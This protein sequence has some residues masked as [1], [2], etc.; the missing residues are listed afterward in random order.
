MVVAG[1]ELVLELAARVGVSGVGLFRAWARVALGVGSVDTRV[2]PKIGLSAGLSAGGDD[3]WHWRG[4][5]GR[6]GESFGVRRS[7]TF[8]RATG[9][10]VLGSSRPSKTGGLWSRR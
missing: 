9:F 7:I 5:F 10:S 3:G 1:V 2:S 8:L 6:F 4:C